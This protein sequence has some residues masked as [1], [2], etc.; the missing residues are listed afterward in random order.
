MKRIGAILL[1]VVLCC[2]ACSFQNKEESVSLLEEDSSNI[3]SLSDNEASSLPAQ[4]DSNDKPEK[5]DSELS[6]EGVKVPAQAGA[7][8]QSNA[9][10]T[11][12][13]YQGL[14]QE[15]WQKLQDQRE[16]YGDLSEDELSE[17]VFNG[18]IEC[19]NF[20]HFF[21]EDSIAVEFI[22]YVG[23]D[24]FERW[25]S[26]RSRT[27]QCTDIYSFAEHFYIS[28]DELVSLIEENYLA[29]IYDIETV[30]N[31]YT[32]FIDLQNGNTE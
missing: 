20:I 28:Q 5:Q 3:S 17:A 23:S 26:E 2:T 21:W 27:G 29:E 18:E 15:Q 8:A 24:E 1:L 9:P 16:K 19:R 7:Q 4:E 22:R 32:Y 11:T 30:K 6:K 13:D 31:R 14:T 25:V 10:S 12:P